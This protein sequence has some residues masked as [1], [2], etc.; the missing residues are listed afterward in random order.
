MN[1]FASIVWALQMVPKKQNGNLVQN[2]SN[3]L[4]KIEETENIGLN[5]IARGIVK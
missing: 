2:G 3:S 4:I 1:I 5:K